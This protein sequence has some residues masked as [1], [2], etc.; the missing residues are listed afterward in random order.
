MDFKIVPFEEK[1]LDEMAE[2]VVSSYQVPGYEWN[3][4][5]AKKYLQKYY[6]ESADYCFAAIDNTNHCL[7]AIFCCTTPYGKGD[8]LYVSE[9]QV[10]PEFRRQGVARALMEKALE[11]GKKS[12]CVGSVLLAKHGKFTVDFYKSLGYDLSGWVDMEV[13]FK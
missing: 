2:V 4:P 6:P 8:Y 1:W 3:L 11:A 10:K 9:V 5:T 12:G 13:K 7:G